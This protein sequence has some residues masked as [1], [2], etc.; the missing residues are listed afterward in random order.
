MTTAASEDLVDVHDRMPV[1]LD[2]EQADLW[3]DGATDRDELENLMRPGRPG[4]LALREV[5]RR[6]NSVRN[7]DEECLRPAE[8]QSDLFG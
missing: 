4:R 2:R 8:E 3:L 6:V 5:S 1:I 7:D